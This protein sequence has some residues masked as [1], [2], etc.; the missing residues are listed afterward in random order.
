MSHMEQAMQD[1]IEG[2]IHLQNAI[3][4]DALEVYWKTHTMPLDMKMQRD[5]LLE[6]LS[7]LCS[8]IRRDA[9]QLSGKSLGFAEAAIAKATGA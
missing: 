9:P 5:E 3:F 6:A 7:A 8:L 4:D 1:Q 2:L